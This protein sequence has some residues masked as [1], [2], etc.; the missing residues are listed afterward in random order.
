MSPDTSPNYKK[1]NSIQN[2]NTPI[3][4]IKD[5]DVKKIGR[6]ISNG[7]ERGFMAGGRARG[8]QATR[9]RGASL[10]INPRRYYATLTSR[11]GRTSWSLSPL[12][13]GSIYAEISRVLFALWMLA[14]DVFPKGP[15]VRFRYRDIFFPSLLTGSQAGYYYRCR[16]VIVSPEAA[17][18]HSKAKFI[19]LWKSI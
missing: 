11:W 15:R 8:A 7:I 4:T 5:R 17:R 18:I 13:R 19:L 14:M 16:H 10:N 1:R 2:S 6:K 12:S 9:P 3:V